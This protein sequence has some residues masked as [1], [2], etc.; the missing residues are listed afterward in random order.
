MLPSAAALLDRVDDF[1]APTLQQQVA[2]LERARQKDIAYDPEHPS[3]PSWWPALRETPKAPTRI[4]RG[5]K[6]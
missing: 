4:R 3:D 5:C 1:L 6:K 2:W